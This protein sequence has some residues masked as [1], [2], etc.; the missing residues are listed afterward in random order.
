MKLASA[1]RRERPRSC[2]SAALPGTGGGALIQLG[3]CR[4]SDVMR[5]LPVW[6]EQSLTQRLGCFFVAPQR[7]QQ[8]APACQASALQLL[9]PQLDLLSRF[10]FGPCP[11]LCRTQPFCRE[12]GERAS[13]CGGGLPVLA[14]GLRVSAKLRNAA[15]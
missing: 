6:Q 12:D 11:P 14:G 10:A 3:Q 4:T 15:Q 1:S 2:E 5:E 9:P 7:M 13:L 8:Q